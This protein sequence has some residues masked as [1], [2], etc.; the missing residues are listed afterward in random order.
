MRLV[1]SQMHAQHCVFES[2]AAGGY[3]KTRFDS[4]WLLAVRNRAKA[5]HVELLW[6]RRSGPARRLRVAFGAIA[7]RAA[8][9]LSLAGQDRPRVGAPPTPQHSAIRGRAQ[10]GTTNAAL[11]LRSQ[12]QAS[13]KT[14]RPFG[15]GRRQRREGRPGRGAVSPRL[16]WARGLRRGPQALGTAVGAAAEIYRFTDAQRAGFAAESTRLRIARRWLGDISGL[17]GASGVGVAEGAPLS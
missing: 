11:G 17:R 9:R 4:G 13:R 5:H 3:D 8:R 16:G 12:G 2:S 15:Q 7:A 10:G 1:R 6:P 14:S